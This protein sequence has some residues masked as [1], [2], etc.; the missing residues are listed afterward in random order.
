MGHA[1]MI[2]GFVEPCLLLLLHRDETHGYDMLDQLEEFG[3]GNETLDSSV[4]Y[5]SLREMEERGLVVSNWDTEGQGP[6]RRVYQLTPEGDRYL[7]SWISGLRRTREVLDRFL[8]AYEAHMRLEDHP[9]T[10]ERIAEV[11]NRI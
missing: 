3:L 7:A 2:R 4:V 5:R 11:D 10:V 1:R 9:V 8:L 6:P